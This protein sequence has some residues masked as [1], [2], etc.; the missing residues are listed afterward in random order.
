MDRVV[1]VR[2]LTAKAQVRHQATLCGICGGKSNIET[3]FSKITLVFLRLFHQY[4]ILIF[5]YMLLSP[6]R[7]LRT[8][9]KVKLFRKS[10]S[11]G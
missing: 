11:N 7:S 2:R 10:G 8:F 5:I 4:A 3:G 1:T 9:Q 6:G